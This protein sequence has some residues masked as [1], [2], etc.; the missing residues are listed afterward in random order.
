MSDVVFNLKPWV[1]AAKLMTL[2]SP[3]RRKVYKQWAA[4]FRSFLQL[5][6]DK[7]SRGGGNWPRLKKQT[8]ARRRTG[9]RAKK[10]GRKTSLLRDTDTMFSALDVRFTSKPGAIEKMVRNG[11][12]VGFG[13]PAK[14]PKASMTVAKLAVIHQEGKGNVPQRKIIVGPDRR[15]K[16]GMASD[17]VRGWKKKVK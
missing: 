3:A 8:I 6:F 10:I 17:V 15:T 4:R 11:I 9:R 1:D 2:D 14:H 13:G 7:F 16:Q 12:K 5:R